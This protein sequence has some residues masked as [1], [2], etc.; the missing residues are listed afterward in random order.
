MLAWTSAS[1]FACPKVAKSS[2]PLKVAFVIKFTIGLGVVGNIEKGAV[3]LGE[4]G[5][6]AAGV[7]GF[8]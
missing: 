5:L 4:L 6:P 8:A 3:S 1:I 7:D 2:K